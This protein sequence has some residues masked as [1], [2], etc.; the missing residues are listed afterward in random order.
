MLY[1][2]A[3]LDA[4]STCLID[5]FHSDNQSVIIQGSDQS[6]QKLETSVGQLISSVSSEGMFC[7][8][9]CTTIV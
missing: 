8:H 9:M 7:G 5:S 2:I 6:S 1:T 4:S 3:I